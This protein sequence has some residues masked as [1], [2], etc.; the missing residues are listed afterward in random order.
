MSVFK[1]NW[2]FHDG[3]TLWLP[4]SLEIII[5]TFINEQD[6]CLSVKKLFKD[7]NAFTF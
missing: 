5:L 6:K 3:F 1:A 2:S 7:G 4:D